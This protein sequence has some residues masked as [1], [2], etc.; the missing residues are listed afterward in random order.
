[1][2][3]ARPERARFL[4]I[5]HVSAV[6]DVE[7][8]VGEHQRPRQRRDPRRE[9]GS[10]PHDLRARRGQSRYSKSLTTRAT[11]PTLAAAAPAVSPS[12][13]V[14]RPIRDTTSF[15]VTAFTRVASI[16]SVCIIRA[17]A[18]AGIQPSVVRP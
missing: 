2:D 13:R 6:Q 17:L 5:G 7:A 10:V 15:S 3:E 18:L 8:A 4:E 11:P 12:A 14:A 16:F 1:D 9:V